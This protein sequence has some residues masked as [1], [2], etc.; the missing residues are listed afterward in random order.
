VDAR[1][2][3]LVFED[4]FLPGEAVLGPILAVASGTA[5]V[6][7]RDATKLGLTTGAEPN[8]ILG[9]PV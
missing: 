5:G 2:F 4:R 9:S 7:D 1:D 6:V 8:A 3:V